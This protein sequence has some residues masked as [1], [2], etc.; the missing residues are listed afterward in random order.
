MR[1]SAVAAVAGLRGAL[2]EESGLGSAAGAR[3]GARGAARPAGPGAAAPLRGGEGGG[4]ERASFG[5][6][7]LLLRSRG[8]ICLYFKAV[9]ILLIIKRFLLLAPQIYQW[10]HDLKPKQNTSRPIATFGSRKLMAKGFCVDFFF[11]K[12]QQIPISTRSFYW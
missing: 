12:A 1:V 8:P 10:Q 3:S 7:E 9:P 6:G 5:P 11:F 2:R 4:G